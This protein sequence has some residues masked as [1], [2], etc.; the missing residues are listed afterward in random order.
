MTA[1]TPE[2]LRALADAEANRRDDRQDPYWTSKA[3]KALRAAADQIEAA[4]A[5]DDGYRNGYAVGYS[6]A[7]GKYRVT[8]DHQEAR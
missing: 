4:D 1:P 5:F 7:E 2:Q 3:I 6:H 8:G